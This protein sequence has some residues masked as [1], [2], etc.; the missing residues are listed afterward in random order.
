MLAALCVASPV[1]RPK[2]TSS[3]PFLCTHVHS[4]SLSRLDIQ[5]CAEDAPA[6]EA[7]SSSPAPHMAQ[8][9]S[10]VSPHRCPPPQ[11]QSVDLLLEHMQSTSSNVGQSL[12]HDV[13]WEISHIGYYGVMYW[14]C[15]KSNA[16]MHNPSIHIVPASWGGAQG[17]FQLFDFFVWFRCAASP[18][19]GEDGAPNGLAGVDEGGLGV[20]C[21]QTQPTCSRLVLRAAVWSLFGASACF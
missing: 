1:K 8:G 12:Y 19:V 3:L 16:I 11:G 20:R 15:S 14:S 21:T 2:S 6:M 9:P 10:R 18:E 7:K 17:T 13:L 4:T 5:L